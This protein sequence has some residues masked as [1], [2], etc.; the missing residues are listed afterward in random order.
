MALLSLLINKRL[1]IP[2]FVRTM[3]ARHPELRDIVSFDDMVRMAHR[4]GVAVRS[5]RLPNWQKGRAFAIGQHMHIRLNRSLS[6]HE[7]TVA[8]M[9]ELCHLWRD[10]IRLAPYYSDEVTGGASC[11]FADIFAWYVTSAARPL[12][13]PRAQ[14]LELRVDQ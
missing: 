10:G 2:T 9:H 1:N 8:G 7:Q 11:E 5:V 14:Q 6:R 4:D 12:F 13:D 3:A